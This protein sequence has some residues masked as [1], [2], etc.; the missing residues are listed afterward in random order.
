[1]DLKL[2]GAV[3]VE[4]CRYDAADNNMMVVLKKAAEGAEWP[5][6]EE[7]DGGGR[8]KLILDSFVVYHRED[9]IACRH[10][11]PFVAIR[12]GL[13]VVFTAQ[14]TQEGVDFQY[15]SLMSKR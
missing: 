13:T 4:G 1:M 14:W 10:C 5:G 9:I 11:M 8:G 6:L 12:L 7:A 3:D 2:A 15:F